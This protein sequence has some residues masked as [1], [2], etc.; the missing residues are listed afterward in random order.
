MSAP[1]RSGVL[2]A[3]LVLGGLLASTAAANGDPASHVLVAQQLFAPEDE[4]V[5]FRDAEQL[6]GFIR[7]ARRRGLSIRVALV[8]KRDDLGLLPG[9]WRR[10]Q[11][12]AEVLG[13]ELLLVYQG[14]LLVVMPNG[15]GIAR[16][17]RPVP[18]DARILA[19][20]PVPAGGLPNLPR[21]ALEAIEKLA[22]A[23]GVH[24]T[25]PRAPVT[26]PGDGGNDSVRI[27]LVALTVALL[28]S[29][30]VVA[31]RGRRAR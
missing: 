30:G 4:S 24:L 26:A 11:R 25:V 23:R 2:C 10:P 17:G 12:Y 29:A 1:G 22:Q 6:L 21:A 15:Y 20:I 31:L 7:E 3:A 8:G 19:A 18:P 27:A 9:L 16:R 14:P 13:Q 28:A 5:P